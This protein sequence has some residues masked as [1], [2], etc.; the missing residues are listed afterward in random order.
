M[1]RVATTRRPFFSEEV[2][3]AGII[4]IQ[5]GNPLE[6]QSLFPFQQIS[7]TF[8][9]YS[10]TY[11]YSRWFWKVLVH[12]SN[13]S[14]SSISLT[15]LSPAQI[16]NF[17]KCL[18]KQFWKSFRK[19]LAIARRGNEIILQLEVPKVTKK[20]SVIPIITMRTENF[21]HAIESKNLWRIWKIYHSS[22]FVVADGE[23]DDAYVDEVII[24]NLLF[25]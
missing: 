16:Q 21:F 14:P 15:K 7:R 5:K 20:N 10:T 19:N 18:P 8:I 9:F 13:T 12:I 11:F 3:L 6:K 17:R 24:K 23:G 22:D 4:V 1:A 2:I 25:L